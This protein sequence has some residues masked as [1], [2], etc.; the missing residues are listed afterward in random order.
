MRVI[1]LKSTVVVVSIIANEFGW[2][3]DKTWDYRAP[4]N[5][6]DDPPCQSLDIW[7]IPRMDKLF[8]FSTRG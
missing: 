8:T 4:E 2:R 6:L 7:S 1:M 5:H 3:W